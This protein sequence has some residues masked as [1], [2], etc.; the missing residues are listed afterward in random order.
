M[1]H[2]RTEHLCKNFD[3]IP[4]VDELSFEVQPGYILGIMGPAGAGKTTLLR[5]LMDIV[6][7]DSGLI[8]FDERIISAKIKNAMGYLP[9]ERGLHGQQTLN[10]A[11]MYFAR[12]KSL[13]RKKARVEAVRLMDRFQ[14]IDH[15]DVPLHGLSETLSQKLQIM[16]TIIHNP[17][18][19]ILDEPFGGQRPE[20]IALIRKL[21][22]RLQD[23][24]K[25]IILASS[26]FDEAERVCDE[27]LMMNEGR[28]IL[29]G[30]L[31]ELRT[32]FK[33]NVID[34]DADE[35]LD[36]LQSIFG[37]KKFVRSHRSARLFVDNKVPP[38]KILDVIVKSVNATRIEVSRPGLGDVFTQMIN[39]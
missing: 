17:D 31:G 11:L 14:L 13:S 34:I 6:H 7:P 35:N 10:E 4:A 26:H 38:Q 12:L 36:T 9:Q 16:L 1:I 3:E 30:S 23:E 20:T 22:P 24:G 18:L 15:M 33:E 28:A 37:V 21:L 29:Q 27:I 2:V 19:L 39:R 5:M 32:R 8:A 25:T